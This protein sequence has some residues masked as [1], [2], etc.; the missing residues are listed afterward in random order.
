MVRDPRSHRTRDT[1]TTAPRMGS[2]LPPRARERA[3]AP[4]LVQALA[5]LESV[6]GGP[7]VAFREGESLGGCPWIR[8]IQ[9]LAFRSRRTARAEGNGERGHGGSPKVARPPDAPPSP[10]GF[11]V[12][13]EQSRGSSDR[14]PSEGTWHGQ[15]VTWRLVHRACSRDGRRRCSVEL[16]RARDMPENSPGASSRHASRGGNPSVEAKMMTSTSGGKTSRATGIMM[17]ELW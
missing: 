5:D 7:P 3:L 1:S 13:S 15:L 17:G 2:L 4:Y 11:P 10:A 8:A 16:G 9:A 14:W 12:A 6:E